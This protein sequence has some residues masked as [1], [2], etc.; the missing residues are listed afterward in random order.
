MCVAVQH[1]SS[2]SRPIVEWDKV[3]A[4]DHATLNAFRLNRHV[5]VVDN[6]AEASLILLAPLVMIPADQVDKTV[7]TARIVRDLCP[8]FVCEIAQHIDMILLGNLAVPRADDVVVHLLDR[9]EGAVVKSYAVFVAEVEVGDEKS[10][11]SVW[12]FL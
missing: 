12:Y 3:V 11:H 6:L 1:E 9:V 7:Q 8:V 2:M 5:L 4:Q 10:L